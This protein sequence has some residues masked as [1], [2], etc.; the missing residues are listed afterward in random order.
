MGLGVLRNKLFKDDMNLM[1][2]PLPKEV[3]GIENSKTVDGLEIFDRKIN[4]HDPVPENQRFLCARDFTEAYLTKRV[5]PLQICEKLI[6]KINRSCSEACDPP[7]YGMCQYHR[8]DI[9]AQAEASTSRYNQDE[10]LGPLDGVPVAIKDEL[11]VMGYETRVGTSFL[12]KENPALKDAFLVKKLRDQ[13]AIIIGKT[14]MH[15]IGFGITTNNPSVHTTR[16]PYNT[17]YYCGGSS[18]GS[19]CVVSSG[20]CPIAIGGDGGGSIRIPSS[21]CGI[22]GLKPTCGRISLTGYCV[23][24][25]MAACVDDLALAYYDPKTLHQPSPTLHG[26]Y[27]TNTLSD[28]KIGIFSA[29]NRQVVDPT[30]TTALHTF[31]NEFKL[32]GAEFVEIDIPELDDARIAHMITIASEICS[33]IN[34]YKDSLSLLSLPNRVNISTYGNMNASDYIKAQQV[35]TRMMRNI[36]VVFSGVDLILTPTCAITAPP[37]YP[38]ALKY[39]ELDSTVMSDGIRF[40]SL[41]NFI[42]IPAITVPAG[43]NDK[44]LPVGLQFMAKWY[45]EA[46]LLRIAKVSEEIL[47]SKRRRPAD[48]YWFGDLLNSF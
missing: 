16:N 22:Y 45:D 46:T 15:E 20:L 19:A 47:G 35:R 18:G 48:R 6:D 9:I 24:G 13:G 3:F 27:L 40:T 33:A 28:L 26:L 43:Y 30:I 25:P 38:R 2:L 5:T 7:L 31:I 42:G 12:N 21:F 39:G 44:G 23:V 29:W 11:D 41:A 4:E 37:I 34:G 8:D 32:R 14:N 17:N 10:S 1:P 36:S